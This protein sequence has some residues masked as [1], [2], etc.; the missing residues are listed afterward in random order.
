MKLAPAIQLDQQMPVSI[1]IPFGQQ[2]LTVHWPSSN[3]E[4]CARFIRELAH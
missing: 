1:E 3:P 4:G 2:K